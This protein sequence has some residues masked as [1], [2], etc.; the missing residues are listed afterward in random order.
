MLYYM[1]RVYQNSMRMNV[2]DYYAKGAGL[3]GLLLDWIG[4]GGLV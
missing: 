2:L 4:E 3:P 1:D